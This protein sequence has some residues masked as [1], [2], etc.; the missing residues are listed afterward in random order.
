MGFQ[1]ALSLD[2]ALGSQVHF[3]TLPPTTTP[4]GFKYIWKVLGCQLFSEHSH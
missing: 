3:P 2:G 1:R 4:L